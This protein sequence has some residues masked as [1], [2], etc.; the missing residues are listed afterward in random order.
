MNQ[1]EEDC[2]WCFVTWA[3]HNSRVSERMVQFNPPE[4][5]EG[6]E[7]V[8]FGYH[9]QLIVASLIVEAARK[10][11]LEVLTFNVL[12]DHVHLL[13]RVSSDTE[14]TDK[15][16]NLKGYTAQ[17]IRSKSNTKAKIWASK[18]SSQWITDYDHLEKVIRYIKLN[19][20]KHSASWGRDFLCG[21]GLELGEILNSLDKP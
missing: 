21:F 5:M 9:S 19:H 10:Y 20:L 15:I 3:T 7:P 11:N 4:F 6:L 18:F 2:K 13:T 16:E 8:V 12:P 17:E 1:E 14:L